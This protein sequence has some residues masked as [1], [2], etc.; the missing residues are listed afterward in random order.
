MYRVHVPARYDPARPAPLLVVLHGGGGNMDL[1]ASEAYGQVAKSDSEGFIAVFPNGFSRFPGGRL[2]TWN[3]GN[4]C[5]AARDRDVDDVGFIREVVARVER[6]WN[7]DRARVYAT[8][9]SNGA[10]MAYRLACDASDVF[11]ADRPGGGHGQHP[12]VRAEEPGRRAALP[13]PRRLARAVHRR[14]RPGFA[15]SFAGDRLRLCRGHRCQ[16][17]TA[18]R[19]HGRTGTGDRERR[20]PTASGTAPAPAARRSS[21]ASRAEGGHSWPG[22][23]KPRRGGDAPSQAISANDVMWD[24][25]SRR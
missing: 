13:C 1:Q 8:G 12:P 5:G 11:K 25:F 2:A 17:G 14:T 7:V 22:G 23:R 6:Q 18:R 4:C 19:L 20:A 3:A 9:M 15:G 21:C 10:M 24:F 16:M